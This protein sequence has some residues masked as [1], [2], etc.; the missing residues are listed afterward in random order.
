MPLLLRH[1]GTSAIMDLIL[2]M[3]TK[4]EGADIR[5]NFLTVFFF[6]LDSNVKSTF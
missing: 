1:I 2:K 4:I 3:Y 6:F 5:D